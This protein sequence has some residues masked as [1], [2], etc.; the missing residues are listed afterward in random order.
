MTDLLY[1]DECYLKEC[2]A[3]VEEVV[4]DKIV[5]NKTVFYPQGGGVP[6]D[7]G[8]IICEGQEYKVSKVK[9]EDGKI[10]HYIDKTVLQKGNQVNCTIDWERRYKL[11]Q[12]HTAAH[13]FAGTLSTDTGALITGNQ[14]ELEKTRFDFNLETFDKEILEKQV[15]KANT[16]FGNDHP[17]SISYMLREEALKLPGMVKLA[18]AFPP[19]IQTLRIVSIG[20]NG[21]IDTQ[22]DG[23]CHVANLKEI[24]KIE[25]IKMENK[26]KNNRRVYFKFVEKSQS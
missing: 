25:I 23:G 8:K 21:E 4:D 9:K 15:E 16:F 13:V 22:A 6:S 10:V 14:I 20:K 11:M 2:E 3:I 17:I 19:S 26:G 7:T 1:M 18:G 24:P 5:L 12:Y